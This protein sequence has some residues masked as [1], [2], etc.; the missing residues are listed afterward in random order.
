LQAPLA[1]DAPGDDDRSLQFVEDK[2]PSMMTPSLAAVNG[3]SRH[4]PILARFRGENAGKTARIRFASKA[5][6]A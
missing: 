2:R 1:G 5:E 4:R 3:N 6:I